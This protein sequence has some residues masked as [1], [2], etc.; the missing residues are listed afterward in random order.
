MITETACGFLCCSSDRQPLSTG[1]YLNLNIYIGIYAYI[2]RDG[3]STGYNKT[4]LIPFIV[5]YY[6]G[7]FEF[8]RILCIRGGIPRAQDHM[9]RYVKCYAL[10]N[11]LAHQRQA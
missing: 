11:L 10:K 5:Q 9:V 2:N 4:Y 8:I 7:C 3:V 6:F 1:Y